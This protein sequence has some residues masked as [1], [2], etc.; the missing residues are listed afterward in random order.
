MHP[1]LRNILVF[2]FGLVI[3]SLLNSFI[4][5]ISGSVIPLPEG[6]D[7]NDMES[8]KENIHLFTGKNYIMPFLAHA[9]GTLVAALIVARFSVSAHFKLALLVGVIFLIGGIGVSQ[10]LGTP[11][12]P[13]AVDLIFAYLPFAWI[14]YKLGYKK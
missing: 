7:P 12:I 5:S 3:G 6:V 8:L 2:I 11:M 10:M 9:L 13:T 1:I 14:G 4:V